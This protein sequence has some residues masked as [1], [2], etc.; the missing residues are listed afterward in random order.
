MSNYDKVHDL[1][2]SFRENWVILKGKISKRKAFVSLEVSDF[3][4]GLSI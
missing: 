4:I 1:F 3:D 2:H